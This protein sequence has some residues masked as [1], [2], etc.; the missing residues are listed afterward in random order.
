MDNFHLSIEFAETRAKTVRNFPEVRVFRNALYFL[1]G[2]LLSAVSIL[3]YADSYVP[4]LRFNGSSASPVWFGAPVDACN[5]LY[6]GTGYS[7]TSCTSPSAVFVSSCT[8]KSGATTIGR[9]FVGQQ[10][11]PAGGTLSG[12]YCIDAPACPSGS[13]RDFSTGVCNCPAGFTAVDG[14]CKQTCVGDQHNDSEGFCVCDPT[15]GRTASYQIPVGSTAIVNYFD[16]CINGCAQASSSYGL[17][18][19]SPVSLVTGGPITCYTR[20]RATGDTCVA[21]V[22]PGRVPVALTGGSA[23]SDTTGTNSDGTAPDPMNTTTNNVDPYSCGVAG[24]QYGT[25]NGVG[26]CLTPPSGGDPVVTQTTSKKTTTPTSTTDEVTVTSCSG[27]NCSTS[28]TTTTT[29]GGSGANGTGAGSSSSTSTKTGD[30]SKAGF[31]AENP[32]LSI[33]K[34]GS[35]SG[36]CD[37]EPACDGDVVQCVQAKE[38]FKVRCQNEQ[39]YKNPHTEKIVGLFDAD[40]PGGKPEDLVKAEKALNKNGDGDFD[41]W[42][43]FQENQKQY[44]SISGTCPA[45]NLHFSFKGHDFDLSQHTAMVCQLGEFVKLL[46]HIMAYMVVL[47]MI[48][49]PLG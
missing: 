18:V 23:P 30:G 19:C 29:S 20:I 28:T 14:M 38:V 3:S 17:G 37:A 43:K 25:V 39:L 45:A 8:A 15:S 24:G 16:P 33:C 7:C 36:T 48:L 34:S 47:K 27:G 32:N 49:K 6:T 44:I 4:I 12:G 9:D 41:I 10:Y 35:F 46:I 40:N 21:A 5:N 11:C 22:P 31:C 1:V 42:A 13:V 26:K 2:V